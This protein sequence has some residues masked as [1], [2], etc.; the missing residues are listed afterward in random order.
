VISK[1]V[2]IITLNAGEIQDINFRRDTVN[3]NDMMVDPYSGANVYNFLNYEKTS[4]PLPSTQY[5]S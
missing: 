3:A 4:V 5:F 2:D 1:S